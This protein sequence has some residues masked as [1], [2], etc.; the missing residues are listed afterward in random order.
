VLK[1]VDKYLNGPHGL[2]LF[3]PAYSSWDPRLGRV[4]MFSEGTK[5][6]AAVFCHAATFMVV[7]YCLAGCGD[8]AY[9]AMTKIIPNKQKD[10][11][12]YQTEPYV[13]AEYLVGPQH[14]YLYG[15]GAFTWIT[16]T[17]GWNF[18]AATNWVLGARPDFH[19]LRIDPCIPAKWKKCSIRRPFRGAVY[20]IEIENPKGVQTGVKEL[21]L[22]GELIQ[23]KILPAPSDNKAHKVRVVMG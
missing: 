12:L 6:N 4:S 23:D 15:E 3:Y 9:E 17:A 7:A 14:P 18:M 11:D 10:Y 21:Y 13:Y 22:D 5:E 2:A 20:D 1:S 19:G 16:G 8:K